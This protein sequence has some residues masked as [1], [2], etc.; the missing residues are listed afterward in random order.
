MIISLMISIFCTTVISFISFFIYR[1]SKEKANQYG[2]LRRQ[3]QILQRW[4][5]KESYHHGFFKSKLAI[6]GYKRVLIYGAGAI[7]MQIY[8]ALDGSEIEVVG[9]IDRS[10]KRV[11][12]PVPV[13]QIHE[14]FPKVDAIIISVLKDQKQMIDNL[15]M[16]IDGEIILID[17]I[18]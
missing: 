2:I 7:G 10:V 15:N 11:G 1:F 13:Y 12:V 17:Q 4:L 3:N 18:V 5:R 14:E 6:K 16:Y 9:F 8:Y